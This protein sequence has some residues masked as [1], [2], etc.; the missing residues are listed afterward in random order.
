MK[1]TTFLEIDKKAKE[2]KEPKFEST[3]EALDSISSRLAERAF[4]IKKT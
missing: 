1:I 4:E 3:D 2:S